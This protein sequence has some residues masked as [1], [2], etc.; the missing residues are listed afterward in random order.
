[1]VRRKHTF[2]RYVTDNIVEVVAVVLVWRGI[3][4]LLD[5]LDF[6]AFGGSHTLTALIGLALGFVL[7]YQE[8]GEIV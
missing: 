7:I 2:F 5:Q 3:W 1:M 4:Y 6:F 8:G